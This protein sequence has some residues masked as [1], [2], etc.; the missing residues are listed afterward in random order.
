MADIRSTAAEIRRGKKKK[1]D[2]NYRMKILWSALLHRATIKNH[3]NYYDASQYYVRRGSHCYRWNSMVCRS[4]TITTPAETAEPMEK[5]FGLWTR[6]G[7]RNHVLHGCP[8]LPRRD[9]R[10]GERGGPL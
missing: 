9:P 7:P 10:E 8:D 4:V 1:E 2:R 3:D 5:L 6:L